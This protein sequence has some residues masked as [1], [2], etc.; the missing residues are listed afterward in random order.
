MALGAQPKQILCQI[1]GR[2]IRLSAVGFPPGF[3]GAWFASRLM[4]GMLFGSGPSNPLVIGGM[5]MVPRIVALLASL[6]PSY[7]GSK[8]A[9]GDALRAA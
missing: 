4:T 9:L 7:R 6:L 8:V 2:G 3:I 1:L 5:A